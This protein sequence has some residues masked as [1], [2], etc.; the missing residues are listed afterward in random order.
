MCPA[1]P[2]KQWMLARYRSPGKD[3]RLKRRKWMQSTVMI[4]KMADY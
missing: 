1:E 3:Q 4:Q 2:N